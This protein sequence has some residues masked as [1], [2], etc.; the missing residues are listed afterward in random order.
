[1]LRQGE[2]MVSRDQRIYQ[3]AADLWQEL[4]GEPPPKGADGRAVL[5]ALVRRQDFKAYERL[6][7]RFLRN[8][9]MTW[10]KG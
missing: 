5:D 1:M 10:P 4:Y 6:Q 8:G 7:S 9:Q 3:E 2:I